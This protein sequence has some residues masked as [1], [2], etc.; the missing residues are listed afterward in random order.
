MRKSILV[1]LTISAL[2]P[3]SLAGQAPSAPNRKAVER[4]LAT[5]LDAAP[6]NRAAWAIY[7]VDERGRVL[8]DRNGSRYAVPA[9]NTKLIVSAAAATRG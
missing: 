5:L 8:V 7:A 1:S 3:A 9:S 2:A 6:F 4:R